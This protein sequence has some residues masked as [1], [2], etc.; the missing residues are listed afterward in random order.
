MLMLLLCCS[1]SCSSTLPVV[2]VYR[3]GVSMIDSTRS[4]KRE[5]LFEDLKPPA[6]RR[7]ESESN[8]FRLGSP[9]SRLASC[10]QDIV[11]PS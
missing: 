3:T 9:L 11:H 10:Q 4:M 5:L 1:S 7:S 8:F 6:R 2:V